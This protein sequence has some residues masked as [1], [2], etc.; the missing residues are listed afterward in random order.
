MKERS[1]RTGIQAYSIT[2][3]YMHGVETVIAHGLKLNVLELAEI[4]VLWTKNKSPLP[5]PPS[6]VRL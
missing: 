4:S 6:K 1:L 3:H 2:S 5:L